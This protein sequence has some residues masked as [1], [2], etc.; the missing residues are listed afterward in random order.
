MGFLDRLFG[1]RFTQ[2]PPD[3]PALS[4]AA[5]MREFHP[6]RAEL[7][8]F[9]QSLLAHLSEKEQVRLVRR[10]MRSYGQGEEPSSALTEGLLD[11]DKGQSLEHLVLLALDWK[12]F[13]GFEY[14]A[15][16]LIKAS[17]I[18]EQ[19]RYEHC[20]GQ[21]IVQVLAEFDEWLTRLG[22]RYLHLNTGGDEYV[23]F[24]VDAERV[25]I[26]IALAGAASIGARLEP[27]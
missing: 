1:G 15:P 23:G 20:D 7:K 13:D 4:D 24:I 8:T 3:E 2:P 17:G 25:D 6:F 11:P 12:G 14:Q 19:Y 16:C 5:I 22:K 9:T 10:V 18:Q 26:M 27:F 21:T